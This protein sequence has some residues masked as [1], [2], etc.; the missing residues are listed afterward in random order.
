M[1]LRSIR[2]WPLL[3]ALLGLGLLSACSSSTSQPAPVREATGKS[4]KSARGAPVPVNSVRTT[5]SE[6]LSKPDAR[7]YRVKSGDTLYAI[8]WLYGLDF[9]ALARYNRIDPP[10]GINAGQLIRLD[11]DDPSQGR[12]V[13]K[14]GDS[15]GVLARNYGVSMTSL[16]QLNGLKQPYT[17]HPG[18]LL[19]LGTQ[20]RVATQAPN[21]NRDQ[22]R[23]A[24]QKPGYGVVKKVEAPS[25]REYSHTRAEQNYNKLLTWRW[26][27]KGRV[28][29]G[30]SLSERGNKGLDIAGNRGQAVVAAAPGRVVYAGS[31]L[32][33]Y[34]NLIIIKHDEDY[35]SAYAHNDVLR[36]QEQQE[37]KAGQRIADM[38]SSDANDVRL[39]F[40]IRYRGQSINPMRFLPK[41]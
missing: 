15:L 2:I 26:P 3:L 34:G 14:R 8:A 22:D 31:A 41:R 17:I 6:T 30:F 40:E 16:I 25:G 29:Q 37:V 11:L 39:H 5:R 38:G 27:T 36:V 35:L 7:T 20:V 33:G 10:Y 12:Y 9:R 19:F 24:A 4:A 32:R 13:V 28:V 21:E 23:E 1:M 18:Q